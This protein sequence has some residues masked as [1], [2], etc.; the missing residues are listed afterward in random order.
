R[1]S[2]SALVNLIATR[3][4]LGAHPEIDG[5]VASCLAMAEAMRSTRVQAM[6]LRSAA[7][8]DLAQGRAEQAL[9][10]LATSAAL[11]SGAA[12]PLAATR[13]RSALTTAKALLALGRLDE[14]GRSLR[15]GL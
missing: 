12:T 8:A 6:C 10:R 13:A 3:A 4:E 1:R 11:S 14:A 2:A 5:D 7:Q 9:E 15:D